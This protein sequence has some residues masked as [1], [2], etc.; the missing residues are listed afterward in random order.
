MVISHNYMNT[1]TEDI[2]EVLQEGYGM[3]QYGTV[4]I[5]MDDLSAVVCTKGPFHQCRTMCLPTNASL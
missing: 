3:I 2:T 1:H 5:H 4:Y